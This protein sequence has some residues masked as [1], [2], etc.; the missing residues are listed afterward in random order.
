MGIPAYLQPDLEADLVLP[1]TPAG[2][3][4]YQV[5]DKTSL[6]RYGHALISLAWETQK[7]STLRVSALGCVH[8]VKPC[9]PAWLG[10][11]T[12]FGEKLLE[13]T[14]NYGCWHPFYSYYRY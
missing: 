11:W 10:E 9:R 8:F 4:N 1:S 7:Q 12:L 2:R 3:V 5:V 6:L 13:S 14:V